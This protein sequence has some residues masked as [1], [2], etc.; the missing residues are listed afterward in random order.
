MTWNDLLRY[1]VARARR[2]NRIV[3]PELS[4]TSVLD[5]LARNLLHCLTV[6]DEYRADYEDEKLKDAAVSRLQKVAQDS[7]KAVFDHVQQ[8]MEALEE[9]C[10]LCAYPDECRAL[11]KS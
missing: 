9:P 2:R 7:M 11:R 10:L 3:C 6:A 5:L 8:E 4:V 1:T